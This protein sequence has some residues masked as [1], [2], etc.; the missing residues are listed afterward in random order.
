MNKKIFHIIFIVLLFPLIS[1]ASINAM[2]ST[3]NY[4][5]RFNEISTNDGIILQDR[6]TG[7]YYPQDLSN[8]RY[9]SNCEYNGPLTIEEAI[10]EANCLNEHSFAGYND[11]RVANVR[12]IASL[13]EHNNP[14]D[15]YLSNNGFINVQ[16]AYL[17]STFNSSTKIYAFN[18]KNNTQYLTD[19]MN[20][21]TPI[22]V[23]GESSLAFE[24]PV[25]KT[26]QKNSY[27]M[28]DDGYY[29]K[30]GQG[31]TNQ[32]AR[33][34]K[35]SNCF[36]DP[37]HGLIW[38]VA[39]KDNI[40]DME[41]YATY[42]NDKNECFIKTWRIPEINELEALIN[43]SYSNI[44]DNLLSHDFPINSAVA[45]VPSATKNMNNQNYVLDT[46]NDNN[47]VISVMDNI[48]NSAV[49][50]Y[51]A[52][53]NSDIN[54]NYSPTQFDFKNVP[55]NNAVIG[56]LDIVNMSS[57]NMFYNVSE[58]IG[59]VSIDLYRCNNVEDGESYI[60]AN[61]KCTYRVVLKDEYETVIDG[62]IKIYTSSFDKI[63]FEVPVSG[64]IVEKY[65]TGSIATGQI[66][67]YATYDDGFYRDGKWREDR[68]EIID[69]NTIRDKLTNLIWTSDTYSPGNDGCT[70][71]STP[72]GKT[73]NFTDT[74]EYI[75]C[76]NNKNYLGYND[77][78]LPNITELSTLL[79]YGTDNIEWL[80]NNGF[81]NLRAN[82]PYNT[83]TTNNKAQNE[84]WV[85]YFDQSNH[86][87]YSL[88]KN[89]EA[90]T[91][92]VRGTSINKMRVMYTL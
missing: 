91:I 71:Y 23:R 46:N 45:F 67:S 87:E 82:V 30:G 44:I 59:S 84:R 1:M 57:S 13:L 89:I 21:F 15:I 72:I 56:Y 36:V 54:V 35:N 73:M 27:I 39:N 19:K 11:W 6:W 79:N 55:V 53:Y 9:I 74:L 83:S 22:F 12:E 63:Y 68:F 38:Y 7:L 65:Y 78:R 17:S 62:K 14:T 52:E 29:Q 3:N 28:G 51:V 50:F 33:F 31:V 86:V 70:N 18:F 41:D 77:W 90:I 61:S 20:S 32:D 81:K 75:K 80:T 60:T 8:S 26:Y 49:I 88:E 48:D 25:P 4:T 58:D 34:F 43:Y 42:L 92:P 76:L 10:E 24:F 85:I 47:D 40:T 66:A 16:D 64:N 69:N 5:T 2:P 37:Q